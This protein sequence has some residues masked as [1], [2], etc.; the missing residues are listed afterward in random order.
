MSGYGIPQQGPGGRPGKSGGPWRTEENDRLQWLVMQC[1]NPNQ[2][3]WVEIAREHGTRDAKQCRERWDNHLKPGLNRDKITPSE[4][5]ILMAW[6]ARNGHRWAPLGRHLGRPENMVKNYWYQ[7]NKK[8]ERGLSKNK[9]QDTRRRTSNGSALPAS[10]PM[11]RDNSANAAYQQHERLSMSPMYHAVDFNS[12]RASGPSYYPEQQH[13]QQHQQEMQLDQTHYHHYS[14][15]RTSV[16]SIATNPPSLASDHGSPVDSPRA[17]AELPYPPGQLALPPTWPPPQPI[18][19]PLPSPQG[20]FETAGAHKRSDSYGS[21][22]S[23][24][25]AHHSPVTLPIPTGFPEAQRLHSMQS[26]LP[27]RPYRDDRRSTQLVAPERHEQ[28]PSNHRKPSDP[29]LSIWNLID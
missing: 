10:A 9:R 1:G 17:A 4:G 2:V 5:R 19:M 26:V 3:H 12:Y 14:S 21:N 23:A 29:R 13:Q 7:E 20:L 24:A 16:A 22:L 6:V 15:R 27:T 25:L 8:A 18:D 11:S 28:A